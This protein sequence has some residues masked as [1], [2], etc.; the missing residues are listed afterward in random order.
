M[1]STITQTV[2][3]LG[4]AGIGTALGTLTQWFDEQTVDT[5]NDVGHGALKLQLDDSQLSLCTAGRII[6]KTVD[7]TPAFQWVVDHI[8]S[9]SLDASEEFGEVADISGDGVAQILARAAVQPTRGYGSSPWGPQRTFSFA[10][11]EFS[12]DGSWGT[13]TVI[14]LQREDSTYYDGLPAG[15]PDPNAAWICPSSGDD[16]EAPIGNWYVIGDFTTAADSLHVIFAGADNRC[17][18]YIDGFRLSRF[19]TSDQVGFNQAHRFPV[20]LTAGDHRI[21]AR[22]SNLEFDN[23]TDPGTGEGATLSGNPTAF[24]CSCYPVDSAG[25]LGA[26]AIHTDDE[27]SVLEYPDDP[28]GMPVTQITGILL[29]EAQTD[30]LIP[31]VTWD[32]TDTDFS[33]STTADVLETVTLNVGDDLLSVLRGFSAAYCD[34]TVAPDSLLLSLYPLGG[35]GTTTAVTYAPG[36]N[37]TSLVHDQ[38]YV[39]TDALLVSWAGGQFRYPSSGGTVLSR[40]DAGDAST[41]SEATSLG[42]AEL[43]RLGGTRTAYAAS[44]EPAGTSDQPYT[45]VVVGDTV[46]IPNQ[47]G[48]SVAQRVVQIIGTT[49]DEGNPVWSPTFRDVLLDVEARLALNA[50]RMT[51]APLGGNSTVASPAGTPPAFGSKIQTSELTFSVPDPITAGTSL[52]TDGV[53]SSGNLFQVLAIM[54]SPNTSGTLTFEYQVNGTDVLNGTGAM[55]SGVAM[56]NFYVDMGSSVFSEWL[57]GSK[58]R[59]DMEVTALGTGGRGL[60]VK[61]VVL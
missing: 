41:L 44:I 3:N 47:A 28:P 23:D 5:L 39:G 9:H 43:S 40:F 35:L 30:G 36:T 42:S 25:R 22:V 11:R 8:V 18:L 12:P 49:D 21:A 51:G 58:T 57:E 45:G 37:L 60:V 2:H 13:A 48:T 14:G 7:T 33:D 19:G 31:A 6:R 32:F 38:V 4:T 59:I 15:W 53:T 24:I 10:S 34:W 52:K 46:N 27:W 54:N 16:T 56:K 20:F 50:R 17:D 61:G 55:G 29:D 26:L 1:T